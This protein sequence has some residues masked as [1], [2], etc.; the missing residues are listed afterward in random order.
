VQ[1]LAR[2][3]TLLGKPE[4][5]IQACEASNSNLIHRSIVAAADLPRGHELRMQDLTWVRPAVGLPPGEENRLVG[6]TL[7]RDLAFGDPILLTDLEESLCVESPVTTVRT[8]FQ[9]ST[10]KPV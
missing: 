8:P 6:R 2:V 5:V 1:Q 9:P 3:R 10:S 4:K 7:K